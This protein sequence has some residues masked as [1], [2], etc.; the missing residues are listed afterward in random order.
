MNDRLH[1]PGGIPG[2][3]ERTIHQ[4]FIGGAGRHPQGRNAVEQP[5]RARLD[6]PV[7]GAAPPIVTS[8]TAPPASLPIAGLSEARATPNTRCRSRWAGQMPG[9]GTWID[10][11]SAKAPKR[12][13]CPTKVVLDSTWSHLL[14]WGVEAPERR[15]A[16]N[17]STQRKRPNRPGWNLTARALFQ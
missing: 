8:L 14:P 12:W 4:F 11:G 1:R 15:L 10:R 7:G 6:A 16:S 17:R 2:S 3:R 9:V 5:R 13:R